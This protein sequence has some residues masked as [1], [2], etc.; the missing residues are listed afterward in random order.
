[1]QLLTVLFPS[2]RTLLGLE[3]LTLEL[4]T[5][6]SAAVLLTWGAA[7]VYSRFAQVAHHK[8][9]VGLWPAGEFRIVWSASRGAILS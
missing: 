3:P 8:G 5:L 6:A 2:L 9:T 4:F 7:E 1:L